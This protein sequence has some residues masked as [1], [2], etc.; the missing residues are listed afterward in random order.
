MKVA[1]IGAGASGLAFAVEILKKAKIYGISVYVT[2]FEKN[3]RVGKKLLSTGNGKC[4]LT[5]LYVKPEDYFENADFVS[6]AIKNFDAESTL[7]FFSSIGLYTKSDSEG[8]VYPLSKQ[9]SGVLDS[10]RYAALNLGAE[11]ICSNEINRIEKSRRGFILNGVHS[12]DKVVLAFGSKASVKDFK[13]YFLLKDLGIPLRNT[14]PSLTKLPCINSETNALKGLRAN[15]KLSLTDDKRVI[16]SD[17]G[18]LLFSQNA[19][20]GIVSMQLSAY[21]SRYFSKSNGKLYVYADFVPEYSVKELFALLK[22][23]KKNCAENECEN[24]LLGF[25]PKKIGALVVKKCGVKLSE[26]IKNID[27]KTIY[28]IAELCKN[29]KFEIS[30][31]TDFSNAQVTYGGAQTN[32][33]DSGTMQCKKIKG[34]YCI[35][36][37]LDVDGPCGGYN[38]Q[39]AWASA[40]LC[41]NSIISEVKK[42]DKNK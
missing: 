8:R 34:L 11:I 2:L 12:F 15:V 19:L 17:S 30:K 26:K 41:A 35:G 37:A 27:N 22:E 3:D 13:G 32:A 14:Y 28:T 29:Y 40:R 39:W 1:V 25:M 7:S 24:F 36:E 6:C 4:N 10:L 18:E 33:F 38:L 31:I 9:A 42:N 23:T 20:S 16:F 5:N 21:A